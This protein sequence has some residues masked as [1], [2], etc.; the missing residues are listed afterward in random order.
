MPASYSRSLLQGAR[1]ALADSRDAL[2]YTSIPLEEDIQIHANLS[3]LDRTL[4]LLDEL[5]NPETGAT[6]RRL[7]EFV[8]YFGSGDIWGD[9][10]SGPSLLAEDIETVCRAVLGEE[11]VPRAKE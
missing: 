4:A 2:E 10:P 8:G 11:Q 9:G 3:D 5:E 1:R 7:V 6:A